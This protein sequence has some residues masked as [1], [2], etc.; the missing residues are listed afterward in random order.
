MTTAYQYDAYGNVTQ[1][2]VSTP[3]GASKTTVSSYTNDTVNWLLGRLTG[4]TVTS[5]VP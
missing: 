1:M 2:T 4:S 5:I 3:D